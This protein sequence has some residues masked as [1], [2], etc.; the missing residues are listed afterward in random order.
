MSASLHPLPLIQNWDC[1]GCGDCCR[2]YHVGI[3]EAERQ[4]IVDQ[5]WEKEPEF[6]GLPLFRRYGPPWRRTTAINQHKDG[7][8]IFLSKDQ[9]CRIHERFGSEAKP[10][11]CRLYPFVIIPAGNQWRIGMRFACPSAASNRGRKANE[12]LVGMQTQ[13]AELLVREELGDRPASPIEL[14]LGPPNLQGWRKVS[15]SDLDQ[16]IDALSAIVR[17]SADPMELR[18]RKLLSLT[19]LCRNARFD[20]IQ[21]TR[22]KEFL[23]I[24]TASLDADTPRDPASL[25]PP[26]WIG[27]VLFRQALAVYTRKDQGRKRGLSRK[28]RVALLLAACRFVWGSGPV[29]KLHAGLPDGEFERLEERAGPLP[30]E[31]EQVLERYYTV[32]VESLQFCGRANFRVGFW[33]G[34]ESL[35]LTYPI[36]MWLRRLFGHLPPVEAVQSALTV[37]DDHF[38]FNRV[39]GSL[40]QRI[41]F[42]ILARGGELDRL[43][44]WYSR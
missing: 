31:A 28:G 4:R 13:L 12:H 6:Q 18:I 26:G 38:G 17:N 19:R 14:G 3:S 36:T 15:W 11:P 29:P 25:P 7:T 39:L 27:R 33:E 1:H 10:L 21:G 5:G 16:F 8:C 42:R 23:N 44:A 9:R 24:L 2:E 41:S 43:V 20:T 37:M 30:C 22:L 34:V 40:R 32:K 35:A